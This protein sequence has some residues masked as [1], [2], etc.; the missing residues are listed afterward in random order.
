[1]TFNIPERYLLAINIL[2]AALVIPYFAARTVS[3]MIKL[4]YAANVVTQ[5]V[6]SGAPP[7]S[8]VDFGATRPRMAYN[9][10][11]ERD[12][13]NLAPAPAEAPP[14]VETEDLKITLLGISHL[15]GDVPAFVIVEDQSGDQQLYRLNEMIP[16]VGKVVQIGKNRAII[17]HDGHRV[18]LEIPRGDLDQT[19]GDDEDIERPVRRMPHSYRSP[20]IRNPMLRRGRP[21]AKA[22]GVRK[23]A[24]NR[25]AIQRATI[26]GNMKNMSQLLTEIRALPVLQNG[27][28]NGFQLSEIQPGSIF[29]EIGL[30]DGDVLTAVSGQQ[31][32]DP[33]RALQMLSTLPNRNA[34]T[35]NV[36]RNGAPM[37]LNYTIH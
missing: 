36:L 27:A 22:D 23:L 12:V 6:A 9:V 30:Q 21:A 35:I 32:N 15:T 24:P 25:Y 37:Q 10:I 2:L 8:S 17:L 11:K 20:F 16:N 1:M 14:P 13:F 31:L 7:A 4:H 28:T 26:D 29:Q 33:A 19:G 34:V 3:A 5:P 18:Q